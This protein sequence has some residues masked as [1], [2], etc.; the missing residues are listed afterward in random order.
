[1]K[2]LALSLIVLLA[3]PVTASGAELILNEYNGVAP[4]VWLNGG[5]ELVDDDG[6]AAADATL[7]RV[8]GNGGDWIELVVV[9]DHLDIRGWRVQVCDNAVCAPE[10]VFTNAALL[11]DLRAG[12]LITVAADMGALVR[13]EDASYNP[14]NGPGEDWWIELRAGAG[15]SGTYVSATSFTVSHTN[16]QI[17][18]R[19]AGGLLVFGPGGEGIVPGVGLN[20]REV[21]KLETNPSALTTP[22]F[23]GYADGSSSSYGAPN[24]F[25]GGLG[26]QSL[27]ALRENLPVPDSDGDGIADDG[28][29]SGIAGDARCTGGST[30]GCD[31]NCRLALNPSQ[32]DTGSINALGANGIGDA[33]ECGD[34]D[35]DGRVTPAD[36][37]ELREFLAGVIA[38]VT[39]PEKCRVSSAGN[40]DIRDVTGI[41][42]A[43][44]PLPP[45]IEP[46]CGAAAGPGDLTE[47]LF[48]PDR[49]LQVSITMAPADWDALRFQA[50]DVYATLGP[51]CMTGPPPN[52][53]TEFPA[54]IS[55][56]GEALSLVS[57]RKKGFY[58]SSDQFKPS[59]KV[60]LGEY[61]GGQTISG[62][63]RFT[64]NNAR[65]DP[66]LVKQ[67][68]GY[69]LFAAAGVPASRCNFANV[70]VN[71]QDLGVYVNVE[72]IK[73]PMLA[74]HFTDITG[75]LYEGALSDFR[76]QFVNTFEKKTNEA[77]PSRADLDAI[78]AALALPDE[79]LLAALE[80]LV[81]LDAF[82]TYWAVEGLIGHWDGYQSN[83]NNFWIYFD[84]A[85]GGRLRFL[86]WGADALFE[87]GNPFVGQ[88]G[89]APVVSP[90]ALLARRLYLH[91]TTR[92]LFLARVQ[93]LLDTIWNEAALQAEID[94]MQALLA[95]YSG[96]IDGF[97]AP[98]RSWI[99][100]RRAF[101]QTQIGGGGVAWTAP[102]DPP[103]C[104]A[105]VGTTSGTFSTTYGAS[106]GAGSMVLTLNGSPV[107]FGSASSQVSTA[108]ALASVRVTGIQSSFLYAQSA[109][110]SLH[111]ALMS[112]GTLPLGGALVPFVQT[113]ILVPGQIIR[114]LVNGSIT[115]SSA[116]TTPGAP[117]VGTFSG[118]VGEFVPLP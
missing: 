15:G 61:V 33:C 71:G 79:Q 84:P 52:P 75:N 2:S 109:L 12:T 99:T 103:A 49:V 39:A 92:P 89:Q 95:P 62:T 14:V 65:Q 94:R 102:L 40:C 68:L 64:F 1:M 82:Y 63:D 112:P 88:T 69:A 105:L 32:A 11:S 16:S 41:A 74:R 70:T 35:D 5:T 37:I 24:L 30:A 25:A 57:V 100:N 8:L 20:Q 78:V 22:D 60:D 34:T 47:L 26:V 55:V 46:V 18:I 86:P 19:D 72:D 77:D 31:D 28:D 66:A 118:D 115:F 97:L 96:D 36:A 38:G 42:R 50:R 117:V 54:S 10:L 4:S 81:D 45:A 101:V 7:G 43:T 80:P 73:E 85:N 56:D 21:F 67:C 83:R 27:A 59:L 48:D 98:V 104:L 17:T 113:P 9:A 76:P 108:G 106:S 44:A 3:L 23:V 116:S 51:T 93:L 110:V 13:P 91:P 114:L 6:E 87:N 90:R 53:Y 111:P 107:T 29:F 58:G